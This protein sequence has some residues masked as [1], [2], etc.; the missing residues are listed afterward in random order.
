LSAENRPSV[1]FVSSHARH[2]GSE[3][4]LERLL[5]DL[6]GV[7][8]GDVVTL[9][10]GPFVTRLRTLARSVTVVPTTGSKVSMAQAALRLR[11][12]TNAKRAT[13]IHANG[14]KA[15]LIAVMACTAVPVVWVKHD[16]S[17]DGLLAS[18][19]ASHCAHVVGV[20]EAVLSALPRTVPTS[21]IPPAVE[22]DPV[23]VSL[24]RRLV[25]ETVSL[26]DGAIVVA[27][28][29]RLDTAKGHLDLLHA[30][31]IV[32]TSLP[33]IHVL[34]VGSDE[35]GQPGYRAKLLREIEALGLRGAVTMTGYREDVHAL[36]AGV[37]ALVIP[38][39]A[40]DH[41][42]MGREGFGL[43]G[44]EAMI[45]GTPVVGYAEGALPEVLGECA[46]LSP[47]GDLERLAANLVDVLVQHDLS[48]DLRQCARQ[49]VQKRYASGMTASLMASIYVDVGAVPRH[50]SSRRLRLPSLPSSARRFLPGTRHRRGSLR[51]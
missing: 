5:R 17:G 44:V 40:V 27:L 12:L 9:E 18:W 19:L 23:D 3:L 4:Y 1:L 6:R 14:V 48:R 22:V 15:A 31:P 10:D 7:A 24:A 25:R 42:G 13:V 34:F 16:F 38:S 45:L 36:I 47:S 32:R 50:D 41:T 46:L 21:V 20:S 11:R 30:L 26:P 33:D 51:R 28:V 29:G 49:R 8:C 2:G 37:D 43:V 35:P 39:H